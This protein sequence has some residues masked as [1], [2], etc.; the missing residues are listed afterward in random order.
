MVTY[1]FSSSCARI[2]SS[3]NVKLSKKVKFNSKIKFETNWKLDE[4]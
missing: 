3:D 1:T 2:L 4:V